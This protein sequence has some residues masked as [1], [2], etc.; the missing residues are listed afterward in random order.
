M[1]TSPGIIMK[2]RNI[3]QIVLEKIKTHFTI[4]KFF[5]QKRFS[6]FVNL[7]KLGAAGQATDNNITE[8]MRFECRINKT[9]IQTHPKYTI[10]IVFP[11]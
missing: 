3:S 1:I 5:F 2:M 6:S 7:E 10:L 11:S 8:G 9:R 4:N